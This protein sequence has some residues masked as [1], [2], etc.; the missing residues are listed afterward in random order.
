MLSNLVIENIAVI[1]YASIDFSDGFNCLTG[2]TGAGKSII[3][4]SINAVLGEKTSRELIRNGTDRAK[5]SA[6][7][8]D[9]SDLAVNALA[10][11]GIEPDDG[12]VHIVRILNRES[13][14]TCK[15]NGVGVSASAL[16]RIGM[17][18]INIHGQSDSQQL[19]QPQLHCGFI[20]AL[21]GDEK[22]IAD[23]REYLDKLYEIRR[24][25]KKL[26]M[27]EGEKERRADILRYQTDEI[28][29]ANVQ[30][31]EYEELKARREVI[32][33]SKNILDSVYGAYY[34]LA[35]TDD[36][37]GAQRALFD[38]A[39]SVNNAA[40]FDKELKDSAAAL[41]DAAYS[42]EDILSDLRSYIQSAKFDPEE[43]AVIEDRLDVLTVLRKKYGDSAEEIL[44]FYEKAAAELETIESSDEVIAQL[45]KEYDECY[46]IAVEKAEK[47]SRVRMKT[48]REFEKSIKKELETLDMPSVEFKVNRELCPFT[49]SGID[50]IEF[51]ISAN[52]GESLKPLAKTA[53]GG[54]LSRIMLALKS[55][56]AG[57]DDVGT[58]IFDEIDT[59]VSGHAAGMIARKLYSLSG[60]HQVICITH[61]PVI[62]AFADAHFEISK[63][64]KN[65]RTYTNVKPLSHEDRKKAIARIIGGDSGDEVQISAAGHML[66]E[67]QKF[68]EA[69]K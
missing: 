57:T 40:E 44:D 6:L 55:A 12:C 24:K 60:S 65:D 66:A 43:L 68:K 23:Y 51:Y 59:G 19:M 64:V 20:D 36:V 26:R 3:I 49:K 48:A 37:P 22:L 46:N 16:K 34:A 32:A 21:A 47:L 2:E 61:L 56:L 45:E 63:T 58:L 54:E 50:N 28:K 31:G 7:F 18:L 52:A 62:A 17:T 27:D 9:I 4:D 10:E 35:G 5:V 11:E 69:G 67:A 30:P 25:I 8:T 42:V 38:A 53:S 14:N 15:I 1:E 13:K 33:N 39:Q 29:K 41:N